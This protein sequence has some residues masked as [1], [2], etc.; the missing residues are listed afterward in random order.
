LST[1][2]KLKNTVWAQSDDGEIIFSMIM[3]KK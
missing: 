3:Q 1:K 2:T